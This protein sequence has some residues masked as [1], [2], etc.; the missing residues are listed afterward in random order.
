MPRRKPEE[1]GCTVMQLADEEQVAAALDAVTINPNNAPGSPETVST[2]ATLF[3]SSLQLSDEDKE[4]VSS[5]L[6]RDPGFTAALT[7]KK[8]PAGGIRLSV[9][10]MD[11]PPAS[12]RTKILAAANEWGKHGNVRFSETGGQGQV[13]INRGR[14]GYWSYLGTDIL[15]IPVAQQTMNLEGFSANTPDSE[16]L[17]VVTHEFGHTLGFPHGQLMSEV[18]NRIDPAKA[19]AYFARTNGWSEATT[20]A[21]VLTPLKASEVTAGP[22]GTHEYSIMTYYL[23]ASITRDGRPVRG[24]GVITEHDATFIAKLYPKAVEPPTPPPGETRVTLAIEGDVKSVK[25]VEG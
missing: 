22:A 7:T 2:L 21:N 13:R 10:F 3:A 4:W 11:S 20:R 23:P 24:S 17:R 16:Y 5:E 15:R 6:V 9:S 8:W 1:I 18:V 14:G 12:V 25:I 19:I